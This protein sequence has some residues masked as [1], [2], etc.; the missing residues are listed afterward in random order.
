M[1]HH[2]TIA[3]QARGACSGFGC[4]PVAFGLCWDDGINAVQYE[5]SSWNFRAD[6]WAGMKTG[7]RRRS[8]R[9]RVSEI[10]NLLVALTGSREP[11]GLPEGRRG[12]DEDDPWLQRMGRQLPC[13]RPH[14]YQGD[15]V[16]WGGWQEDR[17]WT[18]GQKAGEGSPTF[19]ILDNRLMFIWSA[20]KGMKW[21]L[22]TPSAI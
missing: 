2:T 11:R 12:V 22:C 6:S 13:P 20:M 9:Q 18:W 1:A 14:T 15:G 8:L 7:C 16:V 5:T 17:G 19:S 4:L 3:Q 21:R 10:C